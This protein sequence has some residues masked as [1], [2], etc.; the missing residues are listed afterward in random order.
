MFCKLRLLFFMLVKTAPHVY[1]LSLVEAFSM[2]SDVKI[3]FSIALWSAPCR[4]HRQ[5]PSPEN[6][7]FSPTCYQLSFDMT[8][9]FLLYMVWN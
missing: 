6:L 7:Q 3:E 8:T 4:I 5:C 9:D 1:P 2:L